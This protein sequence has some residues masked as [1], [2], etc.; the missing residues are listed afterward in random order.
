[1]FRQAVQSFNTGN[2]VAARQDCQKI[3]KLDPKC[4]P[5]IQLLAA[6]AQRSG[7]LAEAARQFTAL[8]RLQ[9]NQIDPHLNLGMACLGLEDFIKAEA[10]FRA[11]LTCN[12]RHIPA[13]T[14]LGVALAKQ[15]RRDESIATFE[16]VL[17][18]DKTF[19][20]AWTNLGLVLAA[21]GQT[22]R[23]AE[24]QEAALRLQPAYPEALTNLGALRA[25][26]N[27]LPEAIDLHQAAL[28][29][30]PDFAEAL[31]NLG[32]AFHR[33]G[34]LED[35]ATAYRRAFFQRPATTDSRIALGLLLMEAQS[36][37]EAIAEFRAVLADNPRHELA[38]STLGLSLLS[39]GKLAEAGDCFDIVLSSNPHSPAALRGWT[40]LAVSR[41]DLDSDAL[42]AVHARFGEAYDRADVLGPCLNDSDPG[43][44][45]RI[46]YLSSDFR[47]HS[48]AKNF[49]PVI[50]DHDRERFSIHFYSLVA[51]SD[52]ITE[53]FRA[54]ADGWHEVAT[55]DNEEIARQIRA[56]AIDI[57]VC[58]A[59]RFD[60]NRPEVLGY[61]AAPIQI[62]LHDVAT[63]GLS[64]ADYI[65]GDRWLLPRASGEYFTERA[66][67]LPQFYIADFPQNLP[68]LPPSP[69]IG[70]VT[71][72]CFNNPT[73]ITPSVLRAW[74]ALLSRLPEAR[75]VLKYQGQYRSPDLRQRILAML[76]E[77]GAQL[78]QVEFIFE[79]DPEGQFLS[80]Y[81][82][83]DIALDT[84]PFSGST[85][86]FQ[87]LCMGV[88]VVTWAWD[89]MV[90]RWSAAMLHAIGLERLIATS[91][92][93]YI[94]IA[95]N[96]AGEVN[97]W[98]GR[99]GEIRA[100]LAR[101]R[102]C[103]GQRW[104]R[105][106]ER[107]YRAMWRRYVATTPPAL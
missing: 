68:V 5:A 15:E 34:R 56:D 103:Q 1:M 62:N 11:G 77:A 98:R 35:A 24:C 52:E 76:T 16:T 101:S 19:A 71:F 40:S 74:G 90:S 3:L 64:A 80:R 38:L 36:W 18:M 43:R 72:G 39:T 79:R 107:L 67:R 29:L 27:R 102:L 105:H 28:R 63:T 100:T 32:D 70:Q 104:T 45:L 55:L 54:L 37:E 93:Q 99:R 33:A 88:P 106:L 20:P 96:A 86:T 82:Q 31:T 17:A 75:L 91:A 23:A 81:D 10:A 14:G 73:K 58:L 51:R 78:G 69:R 65:I 2:P 59:G 22:G 13:L 41:D 85:T 95:L 94:A 6:I 21:A 97:D 83:I 89:R 9:P 60:A 57:L 25:G 44:R 48:V 7:D 12:P 50:R 53:Q 47:A 84:F 49:L 87:A 61:R 66:L 42:K 4:L 30:R 46:G 8:G 92:E 26:Q